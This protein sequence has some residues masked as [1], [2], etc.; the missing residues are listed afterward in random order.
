MTAKLGSLHPDDSV[1]PHLNSPTHKGGNQEAFTSLLPTVSF[2]RQSG[3]MSWTPTYYS[4]SWVPMDDVLYFLAYRSSDE[5]MWDTHESVFASWKHPGAWLMY[6][7]ISRGT[8]QCI[9]KQAAPCPAPTSPSGNS[10]PTELWEIPLPL[11]DNQPSPW[12]LF[13]LWG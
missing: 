4:I 12:L 5:L 8:P 6:Y 7:P 13:R 11:G 3:N 1:S 10:I 2:V 9:S